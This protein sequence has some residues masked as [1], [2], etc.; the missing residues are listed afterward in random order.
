MTRAHLRA[1]TNSFGSDG[2]DGGMP[3]SEVCRI[4]SFDPP[5]ALRMELCGKPGKVFV[6]QFLMYVKQTQKNPQ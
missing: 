1:D 4:E 5:A 6:C 3:F 2:E